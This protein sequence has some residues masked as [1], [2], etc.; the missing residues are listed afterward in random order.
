MCRSRVA[1][2]VQFPRLERHASSAPSV[3]TALTVICDVVG[4][5]T[6]L[7]TL[8]DI[9]KELF[10]PGG[11]GSLS[12]QL[13][14][15]VWRAYRRAARHRPDRLATAG[16]MALV[17]V[18]LMWTVLLAVG[19]ALI[20]WP[21][22]PAAFRFS[23]PLHPARQTSFGDALYFS[24]VALTTLGYGDITPTRLLLRFLVPVEAGLGAGVLTAGI[25][26]TLSLYPVLSR[27]RALAERVLL[28]RR[29][30][31]RTGIDLLAQDPQIVTT[32]LGD[33][34]GALAQVRVDLGQSD[35]SYSF[36][37]QRTLVAM[38]VALPVLLRLA[39]SAGAAGR[40]DAVRL[41]AVALE[42]S[43]CQYAETVRANHLRIG[44]RRVDELLARY[45]A[46]H[47]H[48][49]LPV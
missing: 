26:W 21:Y 20:F 4:A 32:V 47:M 34:A 3:T 35:I 48:E 11:S 37:D 5:A 30:E 25:S 10:H 1:Y 44:D 28:L 36:Y 39:R 13:Q 17:G 27:R 9:L 12:K 2:L 49:I 24:L 18:L 23:T 33:L 22:L 29:A 6:V 19:W 8:R 42:E 46:D 14:R 7:V 45:A 38:P 31:E 40:P 15:M 41:A 16:P 43:V